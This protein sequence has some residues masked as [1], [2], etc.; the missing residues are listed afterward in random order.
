[1]YPL[2]MYFVSNVHSSLLHLDSK[3]SFSTLYILLV[4]AV[5]S[6]TL[7]NVWSIKVLWGGGGCCLRPPLGSWRGWVT[8]GGGELEMEV[9]L[10]VEAAPLWVSPTQMSFERIVVTRNL[11]AT[12]VT[13]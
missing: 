5:T 7:S 11:P 6:R 2:H 12:L 9:C 10:S 3:L 8:L 1:M 13:L 4:G